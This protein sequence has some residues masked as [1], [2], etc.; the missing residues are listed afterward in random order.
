MRT[1]IE[2]LYANILT[3][4]NARYAI[5]AGYEVPS[6]FISL[7]KGRRE[8][9]LCP[10]A[11]AINSQRVIFLLAAISGI[12]LPDEPRIMARRFKRCQNLASDPETFERQLRGHLLTG[13]R[14]N[15]ITLLEDAEIYLSARDDNINRNRMVSDV[16][17]L[18]ILDDSTGTAFLTSNREGLIDEA[19]RS[20]IHVALHFP[21]FG[22]EM[23]RNLWQQLIDREN[24]ENTSVFIEFIE[25]DESEILEWAMKNYDDN[26][27]QGTTWNGDKSAIRLRQQKV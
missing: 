11:I 10:E 26:F 27:N 12:P 8:I 17:F 14:W 24:E 21:K 15:C 6:S 3:P 16:T 5:T 23:T 2:G 20:R 19:L 13:S 4:E 18:Q 22:R 9:K 1:D 25:F 7:T